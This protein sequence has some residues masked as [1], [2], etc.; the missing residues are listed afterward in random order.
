MR[1]GEGPAVRASYLRMLLMACEEF[2]PLALD[3]RAE[4]DDAI[5]TRIECAGPLVWLPVEADL[6]LQRALDAV[7]GSERT[8]EFVLAKAGEFLATSL[9]RSAVSTA[10]SLFGLS[11]GSLARLVPPAWGLLYREC[12]RW[13]V[14]AG[15]DPDRTRARSWREVEMRLAGLPPACAGADAWLAAVGTV[16]H[17]LLMVAEREGE[18]ELL[19]RAPCAVVFRLAW[20]KK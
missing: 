13:S 3:V 8:R 12:G 17:A 19:E 16:L 2:G 7:L 18:V 11:P 6:A 5:Q 9:V 15:L 1:S 14:S 4:L 10:A 20:K